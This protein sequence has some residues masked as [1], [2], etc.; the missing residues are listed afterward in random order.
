MPGDR[1]EHT[2][3]L[4]SSNCVS[5]NVSATYKL[6]R[7]RAA[8]SCQT[9]VVRHNVQFDRLRVIERDLIPR[10]LEFSFAIS[11]AIVPT[12]GFEDRELLM[13]ETN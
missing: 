5:A 9:R 1:T 13:L 6:L 3:L 11:E 4:A 10:A 2:M 12:D 8:R 7:G